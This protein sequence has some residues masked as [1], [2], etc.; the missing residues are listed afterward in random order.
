MIN[1]MAGSFKPRWSFTKE[2]H[3]RRAGI[4]PGRSGR[5]QRKTLSQ[6]V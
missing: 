6:E 1:S 3:A 4:L 5:E 2:R